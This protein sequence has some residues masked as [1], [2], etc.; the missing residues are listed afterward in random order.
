MQSTQAVPKAGKIRRALP[1]ACQ[2]TCITWNNK[3]KK[4]KAACDLKQKAT[5]NNKEHLLLQEFWI[6]RTF[7]A[8]F[9]NNASIVVRTIARN[10]HSAHFSSEIFE[11][12]FKS[13]SNNCFLCEK[14]EREVR[15]PGA[16]G[17]VNCGSFESG[18]TPFFE[19]VFGMLFLTQ[20]TQKSSKQ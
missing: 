18:G 5:K 6:Q 15:A 11:Q 3:K 2:I 1:R 10:S 13:C 12:C 4:K 20:I 19:P 14:C 17:H 16:S 7:P 8:W 9:S